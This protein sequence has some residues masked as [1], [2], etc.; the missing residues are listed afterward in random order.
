MDHLFQLFLRVQVP[1]VIAVRKLVG[2]AL[3]VLERHLVVDPVVSAPEHQ[4]ARLG[5]VRVRQPIHILA[6]AVRDRLVVVAHA[7][8]GPVT[9]VLV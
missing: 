8:Q 2:V 6:D 7:S 9:L 1:K 5:P 3:Q 4:P